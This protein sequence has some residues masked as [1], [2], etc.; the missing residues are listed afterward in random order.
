[1]RKSIIVPMLTIVS[2]IIA[3][4]VLAVYLYGYKTLGQDNGVIGKLGTFGD[5]VGGSINPLL[6]FGTLIIVLWTS[7]L[8]SVE[9]A[10]TRSLTKDQLS[11]NEL[12]NFESTFFH[13]MDIYHK[14]VSGLR[15]VKS[16][17]DYTGNRQFKE[18]IGKQ[19]FSEF[20]EDL[21]SSYFNTAF[22]GIPLE[23]PHRTVAAYQGMY[24]HHRNYLGHYYRSLYN[25]L[26]FVDEAKFVYRNNDREFKLKYIRVLRAQLSDHE[27]IIL[28]YNCVHANGTN[29]L[30]YINNN[31]MLDNMPR[32]LL[33]DRTHEQQFPTIRL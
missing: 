13:L 22:S 5:F 7:Y 1:M 29:M 23:E 4:G 20:Y 27:M 25:I 28:Y 19:V 33:L 24:Q 3:I 11:S 32:D 18:I 17:T 30:S 15:I 26:R 8:Q 12:Q 10:S 6:S 14:V 9:L 16:E 21:R 2:G 31:D